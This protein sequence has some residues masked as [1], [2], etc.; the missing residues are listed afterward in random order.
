MKPKTF[1]ERFAAGIVNSRWIIIAVF[2]AVMI[3]TV[4]SLSWVK[5]E[6]DITYYLPESAEA[7]QGLIINQ[8]FFM[9]GTTNVMV[10][11]I[12]S[13]EAEMICDVIENVDG[14]KS[15]IFDLTEDHYKLGCALY[16]V[17][18]DYETTTPECTE[19]SDAISETLSRYETYIYAE[20]LD[21]SGILAVE[22]AKVLVWVVITVL[23][24]LLF[25]SSNYGEILVLVLTF[26]TA[27]V[28]NMSTNFILVEM[29]F[30]SYIVA[31]VLQ[32]ALSVDYAIIYCNRY[33]EEREKMPVK[34]AVIV[35]L[36]KAI[37]EISAS[38]L[39]TIAGLAAMCFMEFRLGYD[40]GISLI[41]AIICSLL[42]V[43]LFMPAL[44]V[45][46]GPLMDKT[47]HRNFIPKINFAGKFA[48]VTK[49]II[50]P[51]FVIAVVIAYLGYS[52]TNYAYAMDVIENHHKN[53]A[54]IALSEIQNVFGDDNMTVI[55]V[56]A[57]DYEKELAF[58]DELSQYD[59]VNRILGMACV[60]VI[61]GYRLADSITY[62]EFMQIA[63]VDETVA[64]AL[65]AY[66]A[67]GASERHDVADNL[68][69]Y[70]VP[71]IDLYLTMHDIIDS[72][73]FEISE[74]QAEL[75]NGLYDQL[76]DAKLQLETEDYHRML[77]YLDLPQQGDDTF[78]FFDKIHVIGEQYWDEGVV[79]TGSSV[80][81]YDFNRTFAKDNTVV[82]VLSLIL[83]MIILLF[84]FRSIGMPLLL[85]LVIQG[86]IWL[87]FAIQAW[88]G[89]YVFFMVVLIVTAIQMGAN[90]DYAIVVSSRF[91]E[92]RDTGVAPREAMIETLN[93][94][95]PTVI[96]SGS[97]MVMAGFLVSRGV[98][99][100][101]IAGMGKHVGIG[102]AISLVFVN[103]ALPQIL[104]LGEGFANKTTLKL[105][106][107]PASLLDVKH[108]R[109][110]AGVLLAVL[111][112][113]SLV[114]APFAMS[115]SQ[116]TKEDVIEDNN[117]MLATAEELKVIA[118]ELS[119]S[120]EQYDSVKMGFAEAVVTDDIGYDE[121]EEG[122]VQIEEGRETLEDAKKQY[123]MGNAQYQQGLKTYEEGLAQYEAS[124][125]LL[126]EGQARYDAGAAQLAD[127]KAQYAE[128]KA[129]LDSITPIYNLLM[130]AYTDYQNTLA[131][132][133][134]AV[135]S[136]DMV[137]AAE[138]QGKVNI[139][140]ATYESQG[141]LTGYSISEVMTEYEQGQQQLADAEVQIA[142]AEAQLADGKAQLDDGYAQLADAEA[143]LS[144]GKA[145][146]DSV[147]AQLASAA[148]QIKDGENQLE[149]A[150]QQLVDGEDYLAENKEKMKSD[151][152]ELDKYDDDEQKLRAGIDALLADSNI[153]SV[154]DGKATYS[155]I[156]DSA[157]K[158]FNGNIDEAQS[159]ASNVKLLSICIMIIASF[160]LM[161]GMIWA[162]VGAYLPAAVFAVWTAIGGGICAVVWK[163]HCMEAG[164]LPFIFV[165]LLAVISLICTD[166]LIKKHRSINET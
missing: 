105:P 5:L 111:A 56:P 29:S 48:Y 3:M 52:N 153:S 57:D 2:C 157:I 80:A 75:V 79:L 12:S 128:G 165:A 113:A 66:Y 61:D 108:R 140:K 154:T 133:N 114:I 119:L 130:P 8:D 135:E 17:T 138:L 37:P 76:V 115:R 126:A 19:V 136:G 103:F 132:Y 100:V 160:A 152:A 101:I 158:T 49:Y 166:I 93:F 70:S 13:D 67:A 26:I 40:M 151:L 6:Q 45:I 31:V 94:S 96:T 16:N 90:I 159:R 84:T 55:F 127:A 82:S 81:A 129:K 134:A 77:V 107:V 139:A 33:K 117:A 23:V 35:S 104:L 60:E 22:M 51:I 156:I 120:K 64:K 150:E 110:A 9:Y 34:D 163:N 88:M 78:A 143:Q 21:I 65:F 91:K 142:A 15:V 124:K 73:E 42:T 89:K 85:L 30:I 141:L 144:A 68:E 146:L 123:N 28:V 20:D 164:V 39:T 72:G 131:E 148:S 87:N 161:A 112:A 54:D 14:V 155:E 95:F 11:N 32:L 71:I 62:S 41:K 24:V 59:E 116:I 1:M 97:M 83:V 18:F 43:F 109:A 7:K 63:D 69:T 44:L 27:A 125:A 10:K 74:E 162:F 118:D 4:F 102:T 145:L 121:L 25:T 149:D 122:R 53:E 99:Q 137:K 38:S 50:P 92:I 86:S 47:K 106:G 46:F 98:S 58:C 36:S 147:S